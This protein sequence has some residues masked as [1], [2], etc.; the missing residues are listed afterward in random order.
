MRKPQDHALIMDKPV[1]FRRSAL[2]DRKKIVDA[3][4]PVPYIALGSE[5][6][7]SCCRAISNC[8]DG[9]GMPEITLENAVSP[10]ASDG[11]EV[12]SSLMTRQRPSAQRVGDSWRFLAIE[13]HFGLRGISLCIGGDPKDSRITCLAIARFFNDGDC[14]ARRYRV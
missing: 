3:E 10:K 1:R 9:N 14:L 13:N 5:I 6:Q 8:C 2:K 11:L 7:A 4:L 12:H